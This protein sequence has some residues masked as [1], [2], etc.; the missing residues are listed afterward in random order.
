MPTPDPAHS[1]GVHVLAELL[2]AIVLIGGG[3]AVIG[4]AY[5]R[6]RREPSFAAVSSGPAFSTVPAEPTAA[7]SRG[8]LVAAGG[9]ALAG[10]ATAMTPLIRAG[11][12]S[13]P[14]VTGGWVGVLF[15]GLGLAL[16][17]V[18]RFGVA[19]L[20]HRGLARLWTVLSIGLLPLLMLAFIAVVVVLATPAGAAPIHH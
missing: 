9:L 11:L 13:E 1:S 12:G 20:A 4:L 7:V 18:R 8:L 17:I 2:A 16:L 5:A 19:R 10:T 3:L 14:A 6:R 15:G